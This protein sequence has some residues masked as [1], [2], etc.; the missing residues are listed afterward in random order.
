MKTLRVEHTTV[1]RYARPV[2]FG[3]HR[4][5]FR[6]RDSHDMKLLGATLSTSPPARLS[7]VH[8][9]FGNSITLAE[10][11][12]I[13]S[14]LRLVSTIRLEH[15]P[16]AEIDFAIE[17]FAETWPFSYRFEE[18]PDLAR[19]IERHYPDPDRR[20]DGWA[21]VYLDR[22][23]PTGTVDLLRGMTRGVADTFTYEERESFGTCTPVEL[24]ER[25]RGTCRDYALFL[26]EAARALGLAARF[27]TGYL[28]DPALD[29]RS[30]QTASGLEG[31]GSTHA[32]TQVYVPGA[33][34]IELDPTNG[35]VG[36]ANLIRVAV[37]R[38]PAQ[39]APLTGSY[40]GA[41]ADFVSMD[42]AVR[43]TLE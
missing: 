17:P 34:W 38:D 30:G 35:I 1:Y 41:A 19:T 32:W 33:G 29:P 4:L 21:R 11:D 42:V 23:G 6:P 3:R 36:G 18:V 14:E 8:D 25:G 43:V 27:V 7:W 5:M 15:Y 12:A 13:A 26:M 24:L 22:G 39:A 40:T 28:Y 2:P 9:A 10:F 37:V 20:V 31:A 16:I